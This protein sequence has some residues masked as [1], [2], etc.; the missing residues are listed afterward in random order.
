MKYRLILAASVLTLSTFAQAESLCQHKEQ[1]I[2]QELE[3]ARKHDNQRKVDG[4]ERALSEVLEHCTDDGLKK[5][6][7][8]KI[9]KHE[10]KV[11][12]RQKELQQERDKGGDSKKIAKREKKLAEAQHELKEVQAAPY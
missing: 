11:A 1:S 3:I 7:Q 8:E 12:E 5:S 6:H 2:K 4:L 10:E 9:R